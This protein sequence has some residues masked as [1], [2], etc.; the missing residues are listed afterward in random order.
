MQ[1]LQNAKRAQTTHCTGWHTFLAAGTTMAPQTLHVGWMHGFTAFHSLSAKEGL[2][3]IT[4]HQ[5]WSEMAGVDTTSVATLNITRDAVHFG[6]D[7]I[8]A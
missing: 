6:L 2:G 8:V 1:W 4:A 3:V 5:W 7:G